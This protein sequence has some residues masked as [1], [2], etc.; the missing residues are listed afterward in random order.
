[1]LGLSTVVGMFHTCTGQR[2]T[3]GDQETECF[4][5]TPSINPN[6]GSYVWLVAT[7]CGTNEIMMRK[8]SVQSQTF[9][10]RNTLIHRQVE[11]VGALIRNLNRY[12]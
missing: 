4:L 1:M 8:G 7:V 3:A 9:P 10:F 6:V 11:I 2:N 5:C 12:S